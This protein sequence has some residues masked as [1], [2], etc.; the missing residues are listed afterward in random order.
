MR[1]PLGG[2]A[3][4]PPSPPPPRPGA[5]PWRE[6]LA[7]GALPDLEGL[8]IIARAITPPQVSKRFDTWFLAAQADR[9]LSLE[10][11]AD[12]GELE[13]IAWFDFAAA[14]ALKL[15]GVTAAVLAEAEARLEDPDRPRPFWRHGWSG[16]V[17]SQL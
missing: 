5:G 12:C 4:L 7:Q 14:R 13:E 1:E 3:L 17:H 11:Q 2:A 16:G 15:A 6:F 10:R 8:D 9:L